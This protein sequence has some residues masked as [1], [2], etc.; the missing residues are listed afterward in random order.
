[1]DTVYLILE[2]V[3]IVF[4]VHTDIATNVEDNIFEEIVVVTPILKRHVS[5]I[6]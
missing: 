1:M 4:R 5:T 2:E 6:L 3:V